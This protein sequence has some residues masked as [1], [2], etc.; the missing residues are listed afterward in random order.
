MVLL[1]GGLA[2]VSIVGLAWLRHLWRRTDVVPD[3]SITPAEPPLHL[4]QITRIVITQ[5][6]WT[7]M[8]PEDDSGRRSV[9]ARAM[10]A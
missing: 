6:R 9:N 2:L 7:A 10:A 8:T 1:V 4:A 5:A 3:A